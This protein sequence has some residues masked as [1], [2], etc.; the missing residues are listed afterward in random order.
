MMKRLL[1]TALLLVT[2]SAWSADD[3]VFGTHWVKFEPFQVA[4]QLKGCQLVYL[5]VVADRMYMNGDSVAVN[6]SIFYRITEGNKLGIA[7]KIGLKN[8]SKRG[9]FERPHFAYFQTANGS[10]AAATQEVFDGDAGYKLFTYNAT[11]SIVQK[12]FLE[13]VDSRKVTI[14]YNRSRG[15]G[16]VMLPLDLMVVDSEYTA[17]QKVIRKLDPSTVIDFIDCLT[18]VLDTVK[19]E[20]DKK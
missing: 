5:A 14:G 7:F 20:F 11:E 4:G 10:T 13:M 19:R 17:E 12:V 9:P 3:S 1:L 18:T 15:G 16:D 6:G 8:L 2:S